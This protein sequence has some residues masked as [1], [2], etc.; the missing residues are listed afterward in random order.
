[1]SPNIIEDALNIYTDGSS[2]S[3]PRVGGVGI[4][5]IY[6]GKNG[7]EIIEDLEV[8]G[9]RNATNNQMELLACLNASVGP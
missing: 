5:Y 3:K 4:R 9:Y 1:M 2:Y 6:I 8:P 7:E